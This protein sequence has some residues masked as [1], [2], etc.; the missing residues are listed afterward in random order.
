MKKLLM[1]ALAMSMA[2]TACGSKPEGEEI[3]MDEITEYNVADHAGDE[4]IVALGEVA[5]DIKLIALDETEYR[6]SEYQGKPTLVFFWASWCGY[7]MLELPAIIEL[8]EMYGDEINIVGVNCGDRLSDIE[9]VIKANNVEFDM[10]YTTVG[11]TLRFD[12][13]SLPVTAIL[14][15]DG[16]VEF[17][18]KGGGDPNF[19]LNEQFIPTIDALLDGGVAANEADVEEV[20]A[21]TAE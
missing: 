20:P 19:M 8:H 3:E 5:P 10:F 9:A 15:A 21:E 4:K 12:A 6:L 13:Q 7:C 16:V 17:Y 1:L 14:G 11:D 18:K 2:L